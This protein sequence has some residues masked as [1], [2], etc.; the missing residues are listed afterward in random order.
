MIRSVSFLCLFLLFA[1]SNAQQVINLKGKTIQPDSLEE[2]L[3]GQMEALNIPGLSLV[4]IN[5]GNIAL[6][7]N[8]GYANKAL[9]LHVT[10]KTIFE[11][12]SLSKSVF[13]TFVMQFVESGILDLDAPL[14][15]YLPFPE[16]EDDHR[17]KKITSR[18]VLSHRSGLPNW[19]ENE[20][21]GILSIKSDPGTA[22]EYSGEGYQ[23]LARVIKQIEQGSWKDV[24]Q[25]FQE[26]VAI[27]LQ[28]SD[29]TFIPD[30]SIMER[31]AEPY[32]ND[33]KWIDMKDNYW[34]K[35]D[36][37][38]FVAASSIHTTAYDFGGWMCAI[39]DRKLISEQSYS[40]ILKHNSTVTQLESGMN[41]YY[42]LGFIT[43]DA[44]Y[45]HT[46][47]HGGSNDGFTSYY[48]MDLKQRWGF[49]VFTNSENG[50]KLGNILWN[51][52]EEEE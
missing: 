2:M 19:R 16:L 8:L 49:A 50:E 39:M 43:A 15:K 51:Y 38:K 21:N 40:E 45:D 37:G 46:Y 24:E 30:S 10:N 26:K 20:P 13:A 29:L 31:K 7:K 42:T 35:K 48:V 25:A 22:Y 23:Y 41:I 32:R 36:K 52:F 17:Y 18:M 11:G 9:K 34:Y 6:Q 12:A 4:I 47:F 5:D 1:Y 3:Q 44:P 33:G 28:L 27:P 14:Y